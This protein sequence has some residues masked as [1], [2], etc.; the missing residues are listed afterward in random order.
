MRGL[1]GG[2]PAADAHEDAAQRRALERV[3]RAE[4]ASVIA[5]GGS[6]VTEPDTYRLLLENCHTVWLKAKPEEHRA[7]VGAQG[8]IRPMAG[9]KESM[10]D[11]RRIRTAHRRLTARFDRAV[12]KFLEMKRRSSGVSRG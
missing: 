10:D 12:R 2:D 4:E 5:T 1:V 9:N 7:R 8:D 11:L 3:L 6:L